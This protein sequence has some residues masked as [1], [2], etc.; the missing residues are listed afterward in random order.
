MTGFQHAG[1]R[2]GRHGRAAKA[3]ALGAQAQRDLFAG[4]H[5]EVRRPRGQ[6]HA[7]IAQRQAAVGRGDHVHLQQICLSD[8]ARRHGGGLRLVDGRVSIKHKAWD[9][10]NHILDG[11][12]TPYI[13][14]VQ[15]GE[16]TAKD[17]ANAL[18]TAINSVYGLTSAAFE[19]AFR[20]PRNKDNIVA[21]RGALFMIDLKN[22]V[23]KR[24]Y[25]VAHI[26]TDSIKIPE[27]DMDIINFV[28]AYGKRY[29]Y[30]FEHEATYDKM[31]LVNNAVYIARYDE[32]ANCMAKYGY[33]PGDVQDHPLGWTATGKQFQVPYVFK[34]LFSREPIEF[35]DMCET[36]SVSGALYLDMNELLPDVEAEEKA[37]QKKL[38]EAGLKFEDWQDIKANTGER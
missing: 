31:C 29:G 14:K 34:T 37:F 8:E 25:K 16:M 13:K 36:F 21:K 5:G 10:V 2:A 30:T 23:Q 15:A 27:A 1:Q 38:K 33:V 26:K 11:K 7:V 4:R 20:D 12:L 17:L 28:M 32:P 9:E 18:K 35:K 19:N 3:D 6:L 24:G 22:E